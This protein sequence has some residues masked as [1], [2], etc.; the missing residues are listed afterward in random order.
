MLAIH[1][2]ELTFVMYMQALLAICVNVT[3]LFFYFTNTHDDKASVF[4]SR[5]IFSQAYYL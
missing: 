3:K 5:N 2:N 1:L 4:S